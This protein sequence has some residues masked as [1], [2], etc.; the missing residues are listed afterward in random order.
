MQIK[1]MRD[2]F[3][4]SLYEQMETNEEIFFVAADFGSPILDKVR[5][6]YPTRFINVGIAEQNLVNVATGLAL[7]GFTV[8]AY[9]IAPFITM[10]CYEQ[11]RVNVAIL[12]QVRP[13][14]INFIGVGAGVSYSMSGPTHHCLEDLSIMNTLPNMEVFSPADYMTAEA[15]VKRSLD[16]K[17]P[18]YIRFDAKPMISI[19]ET[20]NDFEKGFRVL[21]D[22]KKVAIISTG[23]ITQ[24]T[25]EIVKAYDIHMIDLYIINNYDKNLLQKELDSVETI[26]TIEEGFK[27]CGGLD[28]MINSHFKKSKKII[29]LGFEKKYTFEIGDREFIHEKNGIGKNDIINIINNEFNTI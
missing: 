22:G 9:A 16:I 13:M 23:Y 18:K 8:Y 10:R 20:I 24:K 12:S 11:I 3:L 1:A 21:Q 29:N 25:F 7:E 4:Q 26:I 15:Y 5:A 14:N 19:K 17:Q 28:A 2:V 27:N 6:D